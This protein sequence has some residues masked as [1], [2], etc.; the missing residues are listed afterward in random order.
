MQQAVIVLTWIFCLFSTQ[1]S[2]TEGHKFDRDVEL[3]IYYREKH[4]PSV[5]VEMGQAKDNPGILFF[6][7]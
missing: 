4:T 2:L 7:L 1:V 3:L 5:A 6:P